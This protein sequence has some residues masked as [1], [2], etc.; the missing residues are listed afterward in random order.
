MLEI[1]NK[2]SEITYFTIGVLL[3]PSAN[4]SL[5]EV[6]NHSNYHPFFLQSSLHSKQHL[7]PRNYIRF[8]TDLLQAVESFH[9]S[10]K[11]FVQ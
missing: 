9:K 4:I 2:Y 8:V 1:N 10:Y 3:V 5:Q 11:L 7:I 6:T